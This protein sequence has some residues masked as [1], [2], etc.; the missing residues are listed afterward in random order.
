MRYEIGSLNDHITPAKELPTSLK[1]PLDQATDSK[2]VTD[3]AA[4][5]I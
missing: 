4:I 2:I 3:Q 5:V 1:I